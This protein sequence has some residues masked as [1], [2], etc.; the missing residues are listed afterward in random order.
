MSERWQS[1][2]DCMKINR[3]VDMDVRA[4]SFNHLQGDCLNSLF[5]D[6]PPLWDDFPQDAGAANN[7]GHIGMMS[8]DLLSMGKRLP[9]YVSYILTVPKGRNN[10]SAAN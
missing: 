3:F 4:G 2:T 1:G 6:A 9:E 8:G 10:H 5:W 7:P